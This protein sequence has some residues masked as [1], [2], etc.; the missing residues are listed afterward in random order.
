MFRYTAWSDQRVLEA[1]RG[2]PAAHAEA[3]PLLAH[4]LAAEHVWLARLEKREPRHSVWP[5]LSLGECEALAAENEA[6]YRTFVGRL[7]EGPP[8]GAVRYRTSQGQEFVTPVLDILTQVVTHGPYHRGQ[9]A[10]VLGRAG[11]SAVSTEFITFAREAEPHEDR[12]VEPS[13]TP[14]PT[15]S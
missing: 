2:T 4:V 8:T 5:A 7:S 10:K 11:G 1:L 3:L 15:A 12:H 9:I 13:P 14:D 6:G